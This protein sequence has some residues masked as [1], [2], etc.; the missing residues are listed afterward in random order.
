M[1]KLLSCIII[2]IVVLGGLGVVVTATHQ[3]RNNPQRYVTTNSF[4]EDELDQSMTDYDGTLPV[5]YAILGNYTN[6]SVAQSFIP[7]KELLTRIQFLMACNASTS[8][9]CI[10][11]IR[12]NLTEENLAVCSLAPSEFPVVNGT[13]T[14]DQLEWID[15]Y[16][17]DIWVTPGQ[18]YYIVIYTKNIIGNFYWIAGNGTN[19]YP[20]GTAFLSVDDG[21][22]WGEFTDVDGCFK[23]YG[24]RET[25][26]E[27]TMKNISFFGLS[28]EIKNVGNVTAWDVEIDMTVKSGIFGRIKFFG[29]GTAS[30]LQPG[31]ILGA[32]AGT[33]FGL[34][35]ITIFMRV[36]ATNVKEMSI[37]RNATVLLFLILLQ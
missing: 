15:F 7:Q 3:N 33:I 34:G 25:F 14:E 8:K 16:C 29:N 1:K 28:Y 22:T 37:E 19:I 2:G 5:G 13:P 20:N 32:G 6:L 10:V 17:G 35:T 9:P 18:I 36:Y 27:I 21:N 31:F 26:L 24:L 4:Y 23:T 11:A 30:E 12:D